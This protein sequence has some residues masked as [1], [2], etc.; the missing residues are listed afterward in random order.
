MFDGIT[1]GKAG[2][3][4]LMVENYE[5]KETFRKGVHNYLGA[6]MYG[7]ATAEDF[8]NAQTEVSHKP[9]DKIM[10]SFVAQPGVPLL[11]FAEPRERQRRRQPAALLPESQHNGR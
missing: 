11:T 9:I 6:H 4:L 3:V 2:A 8:W 7:N 5:G 1:Y 10:E